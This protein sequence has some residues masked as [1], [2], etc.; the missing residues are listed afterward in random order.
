MAFQTPI[1]V[2]QAIKN[3]NNQKYLLPAIQREFVWKEEQIERI[4]DSIMRGYPI[5]SFLFWKVSKESIRQYQF[6][7]FIKDYHQ[8][9]SHNQKIDLIGDEEIISILD[10]QQRLTS[11][12]IGLMG[13]YASKKPYM[14]WD[15]PNAFPKKYLYQFISQTIISDNFL[16]RRRKK[17]ILIGLGR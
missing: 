13:S 7:S 15:R 5:G 8:K 16:P 17:K 2:L 6:Y 10:G 4:F 12:Y 14:R 9:K 11:L 1:T 3:I